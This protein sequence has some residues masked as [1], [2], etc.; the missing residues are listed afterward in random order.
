MIGLYIVYM[1]IHT[2]MSGRKI[3]RVLGTNFWKI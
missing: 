1:Y 3:S 2:Y